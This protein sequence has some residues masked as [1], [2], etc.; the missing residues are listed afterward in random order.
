M[1]GADVMQDSLFS[2]RSLESFVPYDHPLRPVRDILNAALV[3][4]DRVFEAMYAKSGRDSIAPEKL[5][6]ALTLQVLYGLRSERMLVEQLGYNLLFRWFVGVSIDDDPWDHSTFSKNR[7]RLIEHEACRKLF[8]EVL[9]QARAEG[10][11][12]AEHFSVDGTLVRAW[13]SQKSF[14]P[15]DGPPPPSS[16]SKSNPEVDFRGKPRTNDTHESRTDPDCRL[17]RKSHNAEA[18]PCYMGHVLM[19]NRNGLA[20]DHRLGRATGTAEREAALDM[21]AAQPGERR[22]SVG[23]DKAYDTADFVAGCRSIGVT[24]HVAQNTKGRRSAIDQR[25]TRHPGYE[26]SQVTRKLI[27]TIFGDAKQHGTLRQ[28]KLRGLAKAGMVFSLVL[29]AVNL[30]R[31]PVLLADTG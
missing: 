8:D 9:G 2:V 29:T 18:I 31:L 22:K 15:K 13:A 27:E 19:E 26:I 5:L 12:S 20:V 4:M 30:R 11:L 7:D 14:V 10:L 16:G 25:T 24:P 1:R 23:A 6:R 17:Y 28:L 21:L 3:R